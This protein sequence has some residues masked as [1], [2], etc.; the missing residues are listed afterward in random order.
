MF[1]QR[2]EKNDGTPYLKIA[3]KG[4]QD[5]IYINDVDAIEAI[6]SMSS[7]PEKYN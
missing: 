5:I 6:M 2:K 7:Q 3:A 1:V 4:Q